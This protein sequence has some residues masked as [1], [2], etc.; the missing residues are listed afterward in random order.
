MILVCGMHQG[1]RSIKVHGACSQTARCNTGLIPVCAVA[2]DILK[3]YCRGVVSST[4]RDCV[5]YI[6]LLAEGYTPLH[7][8]GILFGDSNI[9]NT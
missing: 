7:A 3:A 4:L 9:L 5:D 1:D 2:R 6:N 8:A